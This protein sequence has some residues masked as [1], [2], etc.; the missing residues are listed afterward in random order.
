MRT[1]RLRL[2]LSSMCCLQVP[3]SARGWEQAVACGNEMRTL[4]EAEYGKDYKLFFMT[5][6]YCRYS[7]AV[8][9]ADVFATASRD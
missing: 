6:P 4:L 1:T 5:S 8:L 2:L 7:S 9:L 3:L